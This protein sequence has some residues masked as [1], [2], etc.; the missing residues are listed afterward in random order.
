MN[1][2]DTI[3]NAVKLS[4]S[5]VVDNDD[6]YKEHSMMGYTWSIE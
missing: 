6:V 5:R 3:V 4:A 1:D 2:D